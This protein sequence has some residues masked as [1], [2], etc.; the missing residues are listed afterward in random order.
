[1]YSAPLLIQILHLLEL[2]DRFLDGEGLAR[3]VGDHFGDPVG[4]G[5]LDPESSADVADHRAGLH[6][7]ESDDLP[8]RALAV[9]LLHVLD[10]FAPP[11]IAE[12][13]VD[14][15]HRNPLG[16]QKTLEEEVEGQGIE[17][18]DPE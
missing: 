4:L 17:I 1:M 6:G 5:R 14:I 11:F 13:D 8:D 16:I 12:I 15:G 9:F 2:L 10:D 3:R 18:G 7:P